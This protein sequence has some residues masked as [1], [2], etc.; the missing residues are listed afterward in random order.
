LTDDGFFQHSKTI[1]LDHICVPECD[2]YMNEA[3]EV[4]NMM[5]VIFN[6]QRQSFSFEKESLV[7]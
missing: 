3:C 5:M 4:Q 6:I 2:I 1:L 7:P